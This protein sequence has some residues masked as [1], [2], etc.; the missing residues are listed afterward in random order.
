MTSHPA[1]EILSSPPL[2]S[3][4]SDFLQLIPMSIT[5]HIFVGVIGALL[6]LLNYIGFLLFNKNIKNLGGFI[7]IGQLISTVTLYSIPASLVMLAINFVLSLFRLEMILN[8]FP[9]QQILQFT[10]TPYMYYA[11]PIL[12]ILALL[13]AQLQKSADIVAEL[14]QTGT[15]TLADYVQIVSDIITV[16]LDG[17]SINMVPFYIF[18]GYSFSAVKWISNNS[19]T[20]QAQSLRDLQITRSLLYYFPIA[21]L[22]ANWL[23]FM[24]TVV[25]V[26]ASI[27]I[28][29]LSSVVFIS[30]VGIISYMEFVLPATLNLGEMIY[31]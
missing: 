27:D 14:E 9:F 11:A 1:L 20:P 12:H 2:A 23:N 19:N 15:P 28:D 24:L 31:A 4:L 6:P 17:I 3:A 10:F 16:P 25:Q 26:N 5:N 30:F 22:Y 13:S 7:Y 18:A 8:Y 29:S 21:G